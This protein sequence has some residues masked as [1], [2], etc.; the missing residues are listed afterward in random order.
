SSEIEMTRPFADPHPGQVLSDVVLPRRV[1]FSQSKHSKNFGSN[2]RPMLLPSDRASFFFCITPLSRA[3]LYT[4]AATTTSGRIKRGM[5]LHRALKTRTPSCDPRLVPL[6]RVM[7]A[8]RHGIS[9][10]T[11]WIPIGDA[12]RGLY[13]VRMR[14][15][16]SKRLP[17][18]LLKPARTESQ[19]R[20][21]VSRP[22][23]RSLA[24][25]TGVGVAGDR[26]P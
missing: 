16:L 7:R 15:G 21:H 2:L 6:Q 23:D 10:R 1:T 25:E 12:F 22:P 13:A 8:V 4:R 26:R 24:A 5:P 14:R 9:R 11:H 19:H 20:V 18:A 3:T 17:A